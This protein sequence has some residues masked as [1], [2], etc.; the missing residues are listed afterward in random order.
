MVEQTFFCTNR[1]IVNAGTRISH[2]YA[3][4]LGFF[5]WESLPQTIV[6]TEW[7]CGSTDLNAWVKK[8]GAFIE[9]P[10]TK[11][12]NVTKSTL[13]KKQGG[14][15]GEEQ[16][17]VLEEAR[18]IIDQ[19]NSHVIENPPFSDRPVSPVSKF[20]PLG[21][22]E[23][24]RFSGNAF[25]EDIFKI[26][27]MFDRAAC[28]MDRIIKLQPKGGYRTPAPL[29]PQPEAPGS[30]SFFGNPDDGPG[31]GFKSGAAVAIGIGLAGFVAWKALT[32]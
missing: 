17:L 24:L 31:I 30:G 5:E 3:D 18:G 11:Q 6:C 13:E 21:L 1:R 9:G 12:Y 25:M 27:D 29:E 19:W 15:L 23:N 22:S 2:S 32:S 4:D 10:F 20:D 14:L 26:I 7:M 16:T 28:S 8:A